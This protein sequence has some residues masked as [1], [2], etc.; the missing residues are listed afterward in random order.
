MSTPLYTET[1]DFLQY[2]L[3]A[4][5]GWSGEATRSGRAS[6]INVGEISAIVDSVVNDADR[7]VQGCPTAVTQVAAIVTDFVRLAPNCRL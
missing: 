3:S 7:P 5:P 2:L 4:P 1:E 6:P